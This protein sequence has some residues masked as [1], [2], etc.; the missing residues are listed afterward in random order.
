MLNIDSYYDCVDKQDENYFADYSSVERDLIL[1]IKKKY[2]NLSIDDKKDISCIDVF[3]LDKTIIRQ[4]ETALSFFLVGDV[5][6]S[7]SDNGFVVLNNTDSNV[8][9]SFISAQL[10][11]DIVD[12]ILQMN[13]IS[14]NKQSTQVKNKAASK[15]LEK[16]NKKKNKK[17]QSNPKLELPNIIS[18]IAAYHSSINILNIWDLTV[19][20]VY[21]LFARLQQNTIFDVIKMSTAAWGNKDN[22]VDFTQWFNCINT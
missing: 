16:L 21:D 11:S 12:V 22:K 3:Q 18:S 20:Q 14:N 13:A 4:I 19:Y 10:Y 5:E 9:T 1:E 7:F 8:S 6:F 17:S 15:I 2:E